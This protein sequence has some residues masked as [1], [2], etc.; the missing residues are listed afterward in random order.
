VEIRCAEN[1]TSLYPQRLALTSPTN[2]G[3]SV[4]IVRSRVN[5]TEFRFFFVYVDFFNNVYVFV[6][7]I[8]K[9]IR[10]VKHAFSMSLNEC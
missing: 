1:A 4:G 6:V 8:A 5:A 2:G 7:R 10:S 9:L 3:P